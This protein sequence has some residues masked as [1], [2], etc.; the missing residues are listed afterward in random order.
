MATS[1]ENVTIE[2]LEERLAT[3]N[4]QLSS[5]TEILDADPENT[6]FQTIAKDLREV[7]DL[8]TQMVGIIILFHVYRI[9]T[10]G[11]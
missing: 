7:I 9:L 2:E 8:T 4:E 3:F 11:M 5:I 10:N 6:E 1:M